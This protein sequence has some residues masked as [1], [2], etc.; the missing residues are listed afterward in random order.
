LDGEISS[1]ED[2]SRP[3]LIKINMSEEEVKVQ[4]RNTIKIDMNE[5]EVIVKKRIS[6]TPGIGKKNL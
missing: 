4:K 6:K 1:F 5:D 2:P 3:Y